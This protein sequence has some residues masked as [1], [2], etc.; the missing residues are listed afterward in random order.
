MKTSAASWVI[1]PALDAYADGMCAVLNDIICIGGTTAIT[2]ELSP[3][4][5]REWLI[6]G[7]TVVSC[8]VAVDMDEMILG[9]QCR[10]PD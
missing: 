1:R 9:F 8:F 7:D 6:L 2:S 4:E 10:S 3:D 5:M